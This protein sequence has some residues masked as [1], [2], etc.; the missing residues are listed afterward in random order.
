MQEGRNNEDK[1]NSILLVT[2][3][4]CKKC[5]SINMELQNTKMALQKMQDKAQELTDQLKDEQ[6]QQQL[7]RDQIELMDWK[8]E[9][10]EI[11]FEVDED[12]MGILN[13][14]L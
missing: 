8:S 11:K 14:D 2:A 3:D 1:T 9:M 10:V 7:L 5:M 12:I 6:I 13:E 4:N